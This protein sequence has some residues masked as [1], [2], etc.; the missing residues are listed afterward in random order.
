VPAV[1]IAASTAL[2]P[3][4]ATLVRE[5]D[6]IFAAIENYRA[7]SVEFIARCHYEDLAEPRHWP[8]AVPGDHRTPEMIA[9]VTA[10]MAPRAEL[11]NT[12]LTTPGGLVA[13]LDYVLSESNE[14]GEL[15]FDGDDE[16]RKFVRSLAR[17]AKQIA[18]KAAQSWPARQA[19]LYG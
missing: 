12:A 18:R 1:A 17:A 19:M 8:G 14:L 2:A 4:A 15:L 10:T 3:A 7:S 9:L 6:P 13:D 5:G 16:T 11:A